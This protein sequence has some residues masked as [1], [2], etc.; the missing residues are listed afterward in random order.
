MNT[1]IIPLFSAVVALFLFIAG[2][3]PSEPDN[4]DKPDRPDQPK[5][6]SVKGVSLNKSSLTLTVGA[7]ETL[8]ATISPSNASDKSV[9]WSSSS[10]TVAS[11]DQTGKVTALAPG[12]ATVTVTSNDGGFSDSC[13]I[14]VTEE[15]ATTVPVSGIEISDTALSLEEGD[16]VLLTAAVMPDNATDKSVTW[17]SSDETVARVDGNGNVSAVRA[18]TAT[19]TVTSTDGGFSASCNV[20]VAESVIHVT[21][22]SLNKEHI[23]ITSG[24]MDRLGEMVEPENAANKSVVW[25]STDEAVATVQQSGVILAHEPGQ[26]QIIVV[27]NDGQK[28][29]RCQITVNPLHVNYVGIATSSK[30]IYTGTTFQPELVIR[31]PEA[32]DRSVVWSSSNEAVATVNQDGVITGISEGDVTIYAKANDGGITGKY[33][34]WVRN[35]TYHVTSISL[36]RTSLDMTIGMEE[37]LLAEILPAN[38]TVKD[39]RWLS[40]D[41]NVAWVY[42]NGVVKATGLGT[43]TIT[44]RAEDGGLEAHC[45]VTVGGSDPSR[46]TGVRLNM[47]SITLVTGGFGALTAIVSPSTAANQLVTWSS[48]APSIAEVDNAGHVTG[49]R[50]GT[51][52]ITVTTRDG[53]KT[54]TC[55]VTVQNQ[56]IPVNGI[57]LNKSSL[58]LN[59]GESAMLTASLSPSNA[60]N[61]AVEWSSSNSSVATV[62]QGGMV[63]AVNP[64]TARI[65]AVSHNGHVAECSVTVTRKIKSISIT[66]ATTMQAKTSTQL[67]AVI[68]PS[69]AENKSVAWSSSNPNIATVTIDGV[70]T[71]LSPGYVTI[72]ALAKDGSGQFGAHRITVTPP[73]TSYIMLGD[74]HVEAGD[75]LNLIVGEYLS[76]NCRPYPLGTTAA[77]EWECSDDPIVEILPFTGANP[78]YQ[79]TL[80]ALKKGVCIIT[81]TASDTGIQR[82]F[83]VVVRE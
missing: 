56:D 75:P 72:T 51:A 21:G 66:G 22:V 26:A 30:I 55:T 2:C 79:R 78:E 40:S 8:V 53:N 48:S 5:G 63:T 10:G 11:V 46:V 49:K 80:H 38:A 35:A 4:P 33:D 76:F 32:N 27:T 31:P 39:I 61:P 69:D 43:A 71:A 73:R 7:S 23:E 24:S 29:A 14:S 70:V 41:L 83:T 19:I 52:I 54:A 16:E 60:T 12:S 20:T 45:T 36:D 68:S 58:S 65:S 57:S 15:A 28:T 44:A 17:A 47:T 82:S 62:S 1:R 81:L 77:V 42:P 64:G 13:S 6:V 59:T 34:F 25:Y 18:G 50:A 37:T 74:D 67:T 9:N 3:G